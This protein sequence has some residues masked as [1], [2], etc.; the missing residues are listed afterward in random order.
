MEAEET[1]SDDS[2]LYAV[3]IDELEG[4][5]LKTEKLLTQ[6]LKR[7]DSLEKKVDDLSAMTQL[8]AYPEPLPLPPPKVHPPHSTINPNT[9]SP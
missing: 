7:I 8:E 4:R 1:K 5:L 2:L 3:T 9:C 6:A